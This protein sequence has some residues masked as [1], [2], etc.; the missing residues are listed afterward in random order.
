MQINTGNGSVAIR[1]V[2]DGAKVINFKFLPSSSSS[3]SV[4]CDK[5]KQ[6]FV[7]IYLQ[8]KQTREQRQNGIQRAV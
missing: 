6:S 5:T 1:K 8:H 3:R 2:F 4:C 7:L